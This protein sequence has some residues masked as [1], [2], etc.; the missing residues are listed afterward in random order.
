MQVGDSIEL[1][2]LDKC[3]DC[4]IYAGYTIG[5]I[6]PGEQKSK[7]LTIIKGAYFASEAYF[8]WDKEVTLVGRMII[9]KWK[10]I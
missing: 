10:N 9:K 8:I 6:Y 5:R 7:R 1:Y 3:D 4:Y 2:R